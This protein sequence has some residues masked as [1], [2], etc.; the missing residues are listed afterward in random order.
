MICAFLGAN[1][2]ALIA[3]AALAG[4]VVVHLIYAFILTANNYAARGNIRYEVTV[5]EKGVSW[6][7]KNMLVLG[8]VVLAGLAMHLCHFW[9][10]MQ[11]VEIM[12]HHTV[13][14]GGR[15]V[16]PT[17]GAAIMRYTFS[18]WYNV[19][20][21]L[22]WFVALWFHLT[23]GFWSMFQS[24]GF[25]ND[26]WY[27]RLKLISNAIATLV[28]LGFAAVVVVYYMQSVC[29]CFCLCSVTSCCC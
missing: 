19:V 17:D 22:V 27:P 24:V 25:A 16:S 29:N 5:N 1:W 11:F 18:Q 3:T 12:G 26:V 20:A 21:Y 23:H 28:F 6:S 2:Y 9:A 7:S 8:F 13:L 10:K 14:V 4:G 15:V